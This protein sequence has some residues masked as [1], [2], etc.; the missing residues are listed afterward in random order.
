MRKLCRL[1]Y[2]YH[3]NNVC[4]G[5]WFKKISG[6]GVVCEIGYFDKGIGTFYDAKVFTACR[7][8]YNPYRVI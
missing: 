3:D 4:E 2:K 6:T 1:K 8:W 5:E 7:A